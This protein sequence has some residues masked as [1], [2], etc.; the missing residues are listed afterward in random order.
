M[1]ISGE[2]QW[3]VNRQAVQTPARSA[4]R[5]QWV[6]FRSELWSFGVTLVPEGFEPD[7]SHKCWLSFC[8][9]QRHDAIYLT[10][11][12]CSSTAVTTLGHVRQGPCLEATRTWIYLQFLRAIQME[13]DCQLLSLTSVIWVTQFVQ[14]LRQ[15]GATLMW[16]ES[17]DTEPPLH[18]VKPSK[19]LPTTP[20]CSVQFMYRMIQ[21]VNTCVEFCFCG[22]FTE[23]YCQGNQIEF[24][25]W[26]ER[27]ARMKVCQL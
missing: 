3:K 27:A 11:L 13:Q 24:V 12:I 8:P 21:M 22:F 14:D 17:R 4:G 5:P 25:P 20:S 1:F 26:K 23:H 6:L 15:L 10:T 7:E 19:L 9:L 16:V 18:E 2:S